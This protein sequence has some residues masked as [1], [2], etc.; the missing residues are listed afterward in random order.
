MNVVGAPNT[1]VVVAPELEGPAFGKPLNPP[2]A[3]IVGL[4]PSFFSAIEAL[5]NVGAPNLG[6]PVAPTAKLPKPP[7]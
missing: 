7:V 5:P 2:N 6:A 1:G 3:G 4:S